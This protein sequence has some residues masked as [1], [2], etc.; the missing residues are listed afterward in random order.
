LTRRDRYEVIESIGEGSSATVLR[1]KDRELD[2]VVA[3]KVLAPEVAGDPQVVRRLKS[4]IRIARRVRHPNVARVY[5]LEE[6][7][8][9]L[10]ISMEYIEGQTLARRLEAGPV[11]W[12]EAVPLLLTLALALESAHELGVVHRDLKPAN[13]LLDKLGHPYVL[14]FGIALAP[15]NGESGPRDVIHG[16]PIYMAPERWRGVP[17]LP[18]SDFYSLGVLAY[19]MLT[20]RAPYRGDSVRVLMSQ[21]LHAPIP[22][23]SRHLEG[24]PAALDELV[25]ALLAKRP[26]E[27]PHPA[28]AVI[29]A[30]RRLAPRKPAPQLAPGSRGKVLVVEDEA[31]IRALLSEVLRKRGVTVLQ[32]GDGHEGIAL[33]LAERPDLVILDIGMPGLD[34]V[35]TLQELKSHPAMAGRP[36]VML[37]GSL[38]P[39]HPAL[40][41][42]LGAVAY[43]NKPVNGD[44]LDLVLDKYLG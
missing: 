17:G 38:D 29:Q 6:W 33:A 12:T 25:V 27:R 14:D 3:L 24:A 22:R 31:A 34:G 28:A 39:E 21:H 35:A 42:G 16:S 30:L 41:R 11:A 37:T 43:L 26:E 5:D 4:E 20:G 9:R 23:L 7:D 2:E 19:E 13:V 36:V 40:A 1:V 18:A 32:A 15:G 44:V 10:C 8:G